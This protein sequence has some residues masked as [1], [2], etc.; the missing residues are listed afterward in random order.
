MLDA[1][2]CLVVKEDRHTVRRGAYVELHSVTPRHHR[3]KY[4]CLDRVLR[5]APP[6]PS[7]CKSQGSS[8]GCEL[9][10]RLTRGEPRTFDRQCGT[11]GLSIGPRVRK[12]SMIDWHSAM[13]RRPSCPGVAGL[14]P[15]VIASWKAMSSR[16]NGLSKEV[17]SSDTREHALP[18]APDSIWSND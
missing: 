7:M 3:R 6:V 1:L 9:A 17:I 16:L 18:G 2:E 4:E 14:L 11:L 13:S 15:P 8:A 10:S 12:A 5:S